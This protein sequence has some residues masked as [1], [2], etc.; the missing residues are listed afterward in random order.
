MQV[1]PTAAFVADAAMNGYLVI[2]PGAGRGEL[3]LLQAVGFRKSALHWLVLAEHGG[4]LILGLA[5]GIISAAVAVWPALS[6][7]GQGMPLNLLAWTVGGIL[8]SGLLW[9]WLAAVIALRGKLLP[10]LRHE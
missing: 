5:A 6:N 3:A 9:T 1:L 2:F 4:L 10:A 7:P 8:L